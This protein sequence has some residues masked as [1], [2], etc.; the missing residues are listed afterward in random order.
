MNPT[1]SHAREIA[2]AERREMTERAECTRAQ[3]SNPPRCSVAPL[4]GVRASYSIE[5]DFTIGA[6][7][8][9]FFAAG[10]AFGGMLV[11]G[12]VRT[13]GFR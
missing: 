13:F 4:N 12:V 8:V 11:L 5:P 7:L 6:V 10:A 9:A 1:V 2:K 3:C